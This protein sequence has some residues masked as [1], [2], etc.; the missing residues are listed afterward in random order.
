MPTMQ[1]GLETDPKRCFD[2]SGRTAIVTGASSGLG[3]HFARVLAGGGAD[4]VLAARRLERIEMLAGSISENG[5]RAAAAV[6][7][8]TNAEDCDRLVETALKAFGRVDVLVN[9]AG[10]AYTGRRDNSPVEEMRQVFEVNVL[11]GY[12]LALRAA[13]SMGDGASIINLSSALGFRPAG[14]PTPA[15]STSKAAVMRLTRELAL[16]LAGQGIRVNG[17][18][19][20]F[21]PSELTE[22]ERGRYLEKA[23]TDHSLLRRVGRLEELDGVLLL[24]ASQASSYITGLVIPV[25]GGWALA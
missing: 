25:D 7:D 24:L 16:Q 10:I 9:N 4:V 23:F 12:G 1:A 11:G 17:I 8:V 22:G 19:P 18:A 13:Q 15:Y 6:A 5:G 14:F 2:L 20:G 21:F 3:A